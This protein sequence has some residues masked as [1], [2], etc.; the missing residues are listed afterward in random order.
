MHNGVRDC[1]KVIPG[2]TRVPVQQ[3]Q[4]LLPHVQCM[5]S[6]HPP[7]AA[8]RIVQSLHTHPSFN[9]TQS[10]VSLTFWFSGPSS[11]HARTEGS[12]GG[13]DSLMLSMYSC[14]SC[15]QLVSFRDTCSATPGQTCVMNLASGTL[16]QWK[17]NKWPAACCMFAEQLELYRAWKRHACAWH[18][19][20]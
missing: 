20:C 3:Q 16:L 7:T 1:N 13:V 14:A 19:S 10:R 2:H 11:P 8:R 6:G 4:Q 12:S 9:S 5:P 17:H 18:A 15:K